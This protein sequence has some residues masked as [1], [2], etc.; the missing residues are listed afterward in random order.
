MSF[1]QHERAVAEALQRMKAIN[2]L[3]L[4]TDMTP[5]EVRLLAAIC[6]CDEGSLK[7]SDLYEACN[8]HP[9]AVSR[10]MNS[11]E[12]KDLIIRNTRTDNRRITDVVPTEQGRFISARNRKILRAYWQEVLEGIPDEDIETMLRIQNEIMESME[13]VLEARTRSGEG[14]SL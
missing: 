9:T 8:M 7:V 3:S 11:L 10:L 4:I 1:E 12:K 2:Y 6:R 14:A 13:K 5:G